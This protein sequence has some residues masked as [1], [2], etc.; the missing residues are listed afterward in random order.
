MAPANMET[1]LAM[2]RYFFIPLENRF[3]GSSENARPQVS[4]FVQLLQS[5]D[6]LL[7]PLTWCSGSCLG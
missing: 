6:V 1:S 3:Y 5:K 4:P 7:A 2:T